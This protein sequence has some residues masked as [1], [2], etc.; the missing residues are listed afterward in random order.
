MNFRPVLAA[1]CLVAA[2]AP[3]AAQELSVSTF[4]TVGYARSDRDFTYQRWIDRDGTLVRD[5]VLGGQFDL[6]MTPH[7]SATLQLKLAPS[8]KSDS[9]W[10]LVPAWAFVAW[11]PSN[12]L[13]LRAGRMRAPL[14]LHSESM[15]VGNTHDMARLPAEMYGLTPSSDYVGLSAAKTW[16]LGAD[17]LT[18]DAYSGSFGSTA[19]FWLRDG[20]E[21]QLHAGANF[22]NL[23]IATT[24]AVLNFR[25]SETTLRASVHRT[26]TRLTD[27]KRVAVS[28]PFVTVAPG[29]GYYQA[30]DAVPGPGVP[31]TGSVH[32]TIYTLGMD[33]WVLPGWRVMAEFARNVQSDT[34][35]GFD[36]RGGYLAVF[37]SMGRFTPYAS[38]GLMKSSEG[39]IAWTERLTGNQLPLFIP[40]AAQLN[41][42]QRIAG[43]YGYAVDQRSWALGTSYAIDPNQ[44]L[45]FEWQ[46]TRIG[47]LSRFVDTPVGQQAPS[48]T[49]LRIWSASY[50]F[51]Y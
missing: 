32:N 38:W 22:S 35:V 20:A 23:K 34:E 18:L 46:Q 24:G 43:E 8:L 48:R 27:G 29:L 19:R 51:S 36:S 11:R 9:R 30:S 42:S 13:L 7:W 28:Y 45:K 17:E 44:K 37:H 14:Y 10:D 50:S 16:S 26:R 49:Q 4:G 1:L 39:T 2:L 6:R 41:A 33:H 25:S 12:D 21:P 5:T 31:T 47:R 15:D 40:G 3:A